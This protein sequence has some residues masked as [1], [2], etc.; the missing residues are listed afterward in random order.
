MREYR[1]VLYRGR[2]AIEWYEGNKR[3]RKSLGVTQ[4][5]AVPMAIDKLRAEHEARDRPE[6]ITVT[7]AWEGF[8]KALGGRPA[9]IT[10]GHEAKAIMPHFGGM[11][12]DGVREEDC[13]AYIARRR[14]AGRL[15]GTIWTELGHLRSALRWAERKNLITKAPAIKR[16]ERPPPR[17]MRLTKDQARAFIAS[18]DKPHVKLFVRLALATAA[19]MGALLDLTWDRVDFAQG[20]IRLHNPDRGRTSKGRALVPMNDQIA[21][22]LRDAEAGATTK[23]VI[24]WGGHQVRN[25]KKGI[26]AAGR[27]A[28][29][30]WVTAHIFRHSAACMMAEAGVPMSEIAQYLGHSSTRVTE[31]V[32]ARYSPTYLKTAAKALEL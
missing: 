6:V 13:D 28:E 3:F 26:A 16:P 32:Y 20:V 9:A 14:K 8:Q 24:E 31:S 27:R 1:A 22:V 19:R 21:A 17:D 11:R 12:A 2:W 23:W 25:V 18:C 7:Y 29:M 5:N 10:M 15:D 30:Q 4:R